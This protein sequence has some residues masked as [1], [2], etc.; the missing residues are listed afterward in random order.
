MGYDDGRKCIAG[1]HTRYVCE[2]GDAEGREKV[3]LY[4]MMRHARGLARRAMA[5]QVRR[6]PRSSSGSLLG[7]GIFLIGSEVMVLASSVQART[8]LTLLSVR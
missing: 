7:D 4:H 2:I 8:F 3:A 5:G 1:C 6:S